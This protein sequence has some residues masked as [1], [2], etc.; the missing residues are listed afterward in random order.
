MRLMSPLIA[1]AA[2]AGL[3]VSGCGGSSEQ[4]APRSRPSPPTSA[5]PAPAAAGAS[6]RR[7]A[8]PR[9]PRFGTRAAADPASSAARGAGG[10]RPPRPRQAAPAA[11]ATTAL[12]PRPAP[13]PPG[14][15]PPAA[16]RPAAPAAPG[17]PAA[18]AR[19]AGPRPQRR[20]R[21]RQRRSRWATSA[22]TP[23]R[24]GPF[25]DDLSN[26]CRAGLQSINDCG[27]IDGRKLD[28]L[29]RDDGWDATKGCNA[30]RDLVER[31]KV[32]GL[33]C[34]QSVPTNDAI[35]PVHGPPE[36]A[37][38]RQRRL[39]RGAVR[40]RLELPGRRLGR[41]P[42]REP[43]RIPGQE[44]GR[45]AGRHPAL[46]Q[47]HRQGLQRRLQED[48]QG[49]GRR[50]RRVPAANFDDPGTSA[51]I[52]Q[53]RTKTWTRSPPWWT[54]A[55]SPA[56]S[57]KRPRQGYKPRTAIRVLPRSTSRSTP[58][59]DRP[60]R[61]G[62]HHRHR[63]DPRRPGRPGQ[64]HPGLPAYKDT[65]EKYYPKIDHSNW[66]KSG[67]VGAKMFGDALKRL[68]GQRH[69]TRDQGR[70]GQGHRLRLRPR[71]QVD[72]PSRPA[73]V[74]QDLLPGP[75]AERGRQAGLEVHRRTDQRPPPRPRASDSPC[76]D[77][78]IRRA[79]ISTVAGRRRRP[80]GRLVRPTWRG[81]TARRLHG[82]GRL[83]PGPGGHRVLLRR[84]RRGEPARRGAGDDQ[85]AA[86]RVPQ[87]WPP[88]SSGAWPPATP[89]ADRRRR[90]GRTGV[91]PQPLPAGGRVLPGRTAGA[92]FTGPLT[93]GAGDRPSTA[94]STPR[95]PM[96]PTGP[97]RGGRDP[98]R[99]CA[100]RFR[101]PT[102]VIVS[103]TEPAEGGVCRRDPIGP[104]GRDHRPARHRAD[105]VPRQRSRLVRCRRAEGHGDHGAPRRHGQ[106]H[107]AC[108]SPTRASSWP[109][110]PMPG[111]Q[112]AGQRR[113][114]RGGVR[115]HPAHALDRRAG[116]RRPVG[117]GEHGQ[118]PG[119][120]PGR[121]VRG[122]Q[123]AGLLRR[124]FPRRA[125]PTVR[126][127]GQRAAAVSGEGGSE[128]API[129]VE[130][131]ANGPRICRRRPLSPARPSCRPPRRR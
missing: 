28:V 130:Q 83:R 48:H 9:P 30:V 61:G 127:L 57:G 13:G 72:L 5:V 69:P 95:P 128:D 36:G 131:P 66:T 15:R 24:S 73:P 70:P 115:E 32:F 14:S 43:G 82:G 97:G 42:G 59:P 118:P 101:T 17:G 50:G 41:E 79:I 34:S 71:P 123:P 40:R 77:Q 18:P 52:A 64:E 93:A 1:M 112:T 102:A 129:G 19:P 58:E 7:G 92:T 47:H 67:F 12:R 20:G 16:S 116:R 87:A 80:V 126:L 60:D 74:E 96:T 107:A 21:D 109:T 55:S 103:R 10:L 104:A 62:H 111:A 100:D 114:D 106:R 98:T 6:S 51:F 3:L 54:P 94:A 91:L 86:R 119:R 38:R 22:S 99:R 110:T 53:A 88:S 124:R 68:G 11:K 29:I 113:P 2:V 31:E 121:G 81:P 90:P 65:V 56:W 105:G 26:A 8:A 78:G 125:A 89:T 122:V 46:E 117:R 33:A 39:G 4:G 37:Q 27:G 120:A 85:R 25:G 45:Q 44:A 108:R 49:A 76:A 75:A 84:R 63:L 35:T 23:V